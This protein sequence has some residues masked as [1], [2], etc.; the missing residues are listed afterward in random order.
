MS[1]RM[2]PVPSTDARSVWPFISHYIQQAIDKTSGDF[3]LEDILSLI[4]Q[5]KA[6]L[7]FVKEGDEILSTWVTTIENS[8]SHK[9]V[10]VMWAGGKEREKWLH[11]LSAIEEWGKSIGCEKMVIAGRAGW[12][13]V[14]PE[15]RKTSVILEKVL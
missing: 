6:Q 9:W 1:A 7:F 8:P 4:E 2:I 10:R 13:K 14:L 15:Y 11:Y 3:E 12:E 5:K